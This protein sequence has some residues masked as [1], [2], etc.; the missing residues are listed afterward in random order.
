MRRKIKRNHILLIVLMVLLQTILVACS[1]ESSNPGNSKKDVVELRLSHTSPKD[2]KN[3]Y[4]RYS[5]K[6]AELVEENTDGQ[7]KVQTY[8]E[9]ELYGNYIEMTKAVMEGALDIGFIIPA[10]AY[11]DAGI[12]EAA[13]VML[14]RLLRSEEQFYEFLEREDAYGLI[15]KKLEERGARRLDSILFGEYYIYTKKDIQSVEDLKGLIIRYG[16]GPLDIAGKSL[17]TVPSPLAISEAY[18][19]LQQGVID[20]ASTGLD[21]FIRR[22]WHEVNSYILAENWAFTKYNIDLII[23]DTAW[24]KIPTDMQKIIKESVIPELHEWGIEEAHK[25]WDISREEIDKVGAKWITLPDDVVEEFDE[26]LVNEAYPEFKK[27]SPDMK[28]LIE[29]AE[30]IVEQ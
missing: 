8:G 5:N 12:P 27:I 20:G 22:K 18:S 10:T 9:G 16:G 29:I 7:V 23:S 2:N 11:P 28:K 19:G 21:G 26:I 4:S 6:F 17:G 3:F 1:G 13:S 25:E 14:P 30:E 24:S 15:D